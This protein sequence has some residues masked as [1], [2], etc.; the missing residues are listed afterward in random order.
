[1]AGRGWGKT[2]T[3]AEYVADYGLWNDNSRI[4]IVAPTAA[5]GRDTCV[6]GESGLLSCLPSSCVRDWNRTFG[7]LILHNG[8]RYKVFSA[9]KPK[10]LRGP[11][12][13]LA[14]CDEIAQ[15]KYADAWDQLMFGLRLGD[16]PKVIVTTTPAPVK[17]I[18]ELVSRIGDDV[19]ITRGKTL[20]NAGNIAQTALKNLLARYS[21]TRLG[22]QELEAEL[23]EDAEGALWQRSRLDELRVQVMPEMQRIVVAIDPAVSTNEGSDETGIVVVGRGIDKH[24][25]ILGDYS[26]KYTPDGWAD[27]AVRQYRAFKADHIIAEANNG[28]DLVE[29]NIRVKDANVPVKLVH[30]S[31][32]KLVR[33][34]PVAALAEQG[35]FHIVGSLTKLEDQMCGFTIDFDRKKAG[36]SPDR[37]DA[38]V[39]GVHEVVLLG[40]PGSNI[41]E[42]LAD[43]DRAAAD[44]A[45]A[46][47]N[48][49]S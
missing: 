19:H 38:M 17:L 48:P 26:G 47:K 35:K 39:W 44:A 32:G 24:A 28:G 37:M 21:G 8:T 14:W 6:E 22:R 20:D 29:S 34:E 46:V 41:L 15:F 3:G 16:D 10:R 31:R 49:T 23:L 42:Y 18:R 33:A 12:H 13:H 4:A 1:M 5:D 40:F 2:R 36:F 25:Y 27:M 9:E 45:K 7:E 43:K 11:Q 30:A